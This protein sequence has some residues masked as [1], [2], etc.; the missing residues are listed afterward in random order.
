MIQTKDIEKLAL[1]ARIEIG[2]E[3]L[4]NLRKEIDSILGYVEQIQK[5]PLGDREVVREPVRNV[6]RSDTNPH[7][8]GIYTEKILANA[9]RSKDGYIQ[10]KK[11]IRGHDPA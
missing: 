4:E 6:F 1:L 10:V 3:E 5:A 9:P 7:S 8:G 11:I 2:G